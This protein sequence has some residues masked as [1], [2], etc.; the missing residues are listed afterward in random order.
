MKKSVKC[1]LCQHDLD[2]IAQG[3]NKKL[4]GRNVKRFL[5]INCLAGYLEVTSEDLLVRAEAF[6]AQ[7]CSLFL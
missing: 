4:L 3:L 2:K 5:C 6:K 7:G 1:F